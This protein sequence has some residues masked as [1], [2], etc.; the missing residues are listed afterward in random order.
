MA[1]GR[2]V[3]ASADDACSYEEIGASVRQVTEDSSFTSHG[4]VSAVPKYMI[5]VLF[6]KGL[7]AVREGDVGVGDYLFCHRL[8]RQLDGPFGFVEGYINADV[9]VEFVVDRDVAELCAKEEGE[10][11]E[12]RGV[13]AS[14]NDVVNIDEYQ[15]G[16]LGVG[17]DEPEDALVVDQL[18]GAVGK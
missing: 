17:V 16:E 3:G 2:F 15:R 5:V 4:R 11:V 14:E 6:V 1:V 9:P 12:A 8:L 7:V 10:V 13:G 18:G